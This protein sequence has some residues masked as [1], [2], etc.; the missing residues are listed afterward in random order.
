MAGSE[1]FADTTCFADMAG[2][3]NFAY[4]TCFADMAGHIGS[5]GLADSADTVAFTT[6]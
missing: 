1:N 2:S 4:T 6:P 3:E 5:G